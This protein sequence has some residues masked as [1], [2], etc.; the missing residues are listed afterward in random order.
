MEDLTKQGFLLANVRIQYID[1][2]KGVGA[3][4]GRR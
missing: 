4:T 3:I 2:L 1:V